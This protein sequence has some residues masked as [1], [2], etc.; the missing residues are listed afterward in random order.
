MPGWGANV[1]VQSPVAAV[2]LEVVERRWDIRRTMLA[3][4][5]RATHRGHVGR[6]AAHPPSAPARAASHRLLPRRGK[7]LMPALSVCRGVRGRPP[8][9]ITRQTTPTNWCCYHVASLSGTMLWSAMTAPDEPSLLRQCR[10]YTLSGAETEPWPPS[11]RSQ[12]RARSVTRQCCNA[13]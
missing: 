9:L 2:S 8:Q 12:K 6:A 5:I 13:F 1:P 7:Y 10:Q 3:A 4:Y 11:P